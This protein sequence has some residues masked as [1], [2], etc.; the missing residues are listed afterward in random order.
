MTIP[1]FDKNHAI[2]YAEKLRKDV[3]KHRFKGVDYTI[4]LSLGLLISDGSD[5]RLSMIKHVDDSLYAAKDNGRNC[6]ILYNN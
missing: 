6:F 4:T 1:D 2:E 3:E 5:D